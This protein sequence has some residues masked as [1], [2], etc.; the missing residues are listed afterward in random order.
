MQELC[1]L[2]LSRKCANGENSF[3]FKNGKKKKEYK[4]S[5]DITQ[6]K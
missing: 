3:I 2:Y 6:I 4:Y 5:R 1:F